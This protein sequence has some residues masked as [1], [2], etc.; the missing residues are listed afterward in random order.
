[1]GTTVPCCCPCSM[2]AH[3]NPVNSTTSSNPEITGRDI[4]MTLPLSEPGAG[5][6]PLT[7][8]KGYARPFGVSRPWCLVDAQAPLHG[9]E[10]YVPPLGDQP[11]HALRESQHHGD[12]ERAEQ[13]HV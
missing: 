4:F 1:M 10:V 2:A 5:A 9:E 12:G 6:P 8:S 3:P 13:D 11:P 7:G